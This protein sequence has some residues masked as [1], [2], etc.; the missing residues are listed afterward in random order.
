MIANPISYHFILSAACV[1]V[2]RTRLIC[3]FGFNIEMTTAVSIC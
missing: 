3:V 1:A 2:G